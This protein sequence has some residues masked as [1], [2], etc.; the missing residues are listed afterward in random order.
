MCY[1]SVFMGFRLPL[2]MRRRQPENGVMLCGKRWRCKRQPENAVV[3]KPIGSLWS[4][5][6]SRHFV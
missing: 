3:V 6:G 2:L 5:G 4:V 1:F